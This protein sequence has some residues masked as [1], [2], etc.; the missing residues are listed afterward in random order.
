MTEQPFNVKITAHGSGK[1]YW[2]T[3][4]FAESPIEAAHSAFAEMY[5]PEE[6]DLA[7]PLKLSVT[8]HEVKPVPTPSPKEGD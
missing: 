1:T 3:N 6:H 2:W 4:V 5:W 8:V 7:A